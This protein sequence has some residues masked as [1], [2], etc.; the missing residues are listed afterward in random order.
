MCF[1]TKV[2]FCLIKLFSWTVWRLFPSLPSKNFYEELDINNVCGLNL[3]S[4]YF[5][6]SKITM[7]A[8]MHSFR[9]WYV[10]YV[11]KRLALNL[12]EFNWIHPIESLTGIRFSCSEKFYEERRLSFWNCLAVNPIFGQGEGHWSLRYC[13]I[14]W[15]FHA[16]FGISVILI[17]SCVIALLRSPNLG[18]R[19]FLA[20]F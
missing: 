1:P 5:S 8:S 3:S 16:Y 18:D 9:V 13:G 20:R 11:A 19:V 14:W 2:V 17:L 4:L 15:I 7:E 6:I 12:I 10:Q